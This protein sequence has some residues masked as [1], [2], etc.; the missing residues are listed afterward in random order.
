VRSANWK[1]LVDGSQQLLFDV[2]RDP[3]ERND[4]AAERPDLVRKL[5]SQIAAWEKDVDGEAAALKQ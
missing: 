1:L 2:A 5:M 3:G 4:L